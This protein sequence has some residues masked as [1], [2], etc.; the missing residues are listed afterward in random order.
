MMRRSLR[1]LNLR[2]TNRYT[3][4]SNRTLDTNDGKI[5]GGLYIEPMNDLRR[6]N[7]YPARSGHWQPVVRGEPNPYKGDVLV[8]GGGVVGCAA[9]GM[10][11]LRGWRVS[12][13]EQQS[14]VA[15]ANADLETALITRRSLDA[16]HSAGIRKEALVKM[17][18]VVKGVMDHP[19]TVASWLSAGLSEYSEFP[20]K[21]L[22]VDMAMLRAAMTMNLQSLPH[23]NTRLF[24]DHKLVAVIA[25]AKTAVVK[26]LMEEA[27]SATAEANLKDKEVVIA[28]RKFED[29]VEGITYDVLMACDGLGSSVRRYLQFDGEVKQHENYAVKWFEIEGATHLDCES[30]QRWCH[31]FNKATDPDGNLGIVYAFP[32]GK[33]GRFNVMAY[34]PREILE[35]QTA[36]EFMAAWAPELLPGTLVEGRETELKPAPTLFL[37]ELCNN[38]HQFPNV[39]LIGDA[40][41]HRNP[42][43][44]ENL[45]CGLED[46]TSAVNNIDSVGT[47]VWDCVRQ[48]SRERGVSGDCLRFITERSTYYAQARHWNP[49]LRARNQYAHAMHYLCPRS[50]QEYWSSQYNYLYP[51]SIEQMLR[52]RGYASYHDIDRNQFRANRWWCFTRLFT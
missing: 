37:P 43:L 48:Y 12:L 9:A 45:A 15:G 50:I 42:Y 36:S 25:G 35:A 16:L 52:G 4:G 29:N 33:E 21:M 10:F 23:R 3:D 40:A 49:L 38:H 22:C 41:H 7:A 27:A 19:G 6:E 24:H 8:V 2:K 18:T 1:R 44:L 47:S 26:P 20:V 11:A 14:V 39:C 46:V 5:Q 32:R 30:L 51:R 31:R 28:G 13:V 34:M 17:G